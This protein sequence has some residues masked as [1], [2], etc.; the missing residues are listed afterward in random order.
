MVLV[1][2][3][4]KPAALHHQKRRGQHHKHTKPY[5]KA[6]WPY[7]PMLAIVGVGIIAN[8]FLTAGASG[9][10][11]YATNMSGAALLQETNIERV[12]EGQSSLAFN[13]QLTSAAQAKADDM[14]ARGYWSHV[15]P[16]G[17][18][19]WW[20]VTNAGYDYSST[21]E[22]LAY[23]FD[24][25]DAAVT[26]WMNSPGHRANILNAGYQD[27]GFGI[28][29]VAEYQGQ[30]PNTIVV[31]LYGTPAIAVDDV[32]T[33]P[34]EVALVPKPATATTTPAV[35]P[36]I[37]STIQPTPMTTPS[38][39]AF[40]AQPVQQPSPAT[41]TPDGTSMPTP[42]NDNQRVARLQLVAA[43]I[44][45]LQLVATTAFI[46]IIGTI[47]ILRHMYFWHRTLIKGEKF[48]IKHWKLDL[49]IVA[50]VVI[51]A[52]LTRTAGFIH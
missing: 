15:T 45:P 50:I 42:Y 8:V 32:I 39:P 51:G 6:Y 20:F 33:T 3:S 41:A 12:A 47:F 1:A 38:Q 18:Q 43:N 31:A 23:G 2:K 7:L 21:G 27:V 22:N 25:S 28:A 46:A 29:N 30:G 17:V 9:V 34:D 14:A 11:A 40:T 4:K 19:P 5:E 24:D 49:V 35:T 10:L 48:I 44:S 37:P 52:L 26:G 36:P 16:D 13:S